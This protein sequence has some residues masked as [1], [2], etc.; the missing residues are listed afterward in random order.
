MIEFATNE[1]EKANFLDKEKERKK[2]VAKKKRDQRQARKLR[3]KNP[4]AVAKDEHHLTQPPS[5]GVA[6]VASTKK[7]HSQKKTTVVKSDS[8]FKQPKKKLKAAVESGE[9]S[10][11]HK[12]E[13]TCAA[14]NYYP[15]DM[16]T[17]ETDDKKPA[18]VQRIEDLEE[19]EDKKPA[20][21]DRAM[22]PQKTKLQKT[23]LEGQKISTLEA[24]LGA[25][26]GCEIKEVWDENWS[27]QW[28]G[29]GTSAQEAIT[30]PSQSPIADREKDNTSGYKSKSQVFLP[31]DQIKEE[32]GKAFCSMEDATEDNQRQVVELKGMEQNGNRLLEDVAR[33]DQRPSITRDPKR[34]FRESLSQRDLKNLLEREK[35]LSDAPL[36]YY[37][38]LLLEMDEDLCAEDSAR[39]RSWIFPTHFMNFMNRRSKKQLETYRSRVPG[40]C[41]S[42]EDIR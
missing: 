21:E 11:Q 6:E 5:T 32:L 12:Q 19:E 40:E 8:S 37:R 13:V 3:E 23:N 29:T 25:E 34:L 42:F 4:A 10:R 18:A 9:A 7:S 22:Q 30:I 24:I 38:Y 27:L 20:A 15:V 39:L 33:V 26:K 31:F 17:V 36:N 28:G 14:C 2:L 1:V 16:A 35:Y 41:L